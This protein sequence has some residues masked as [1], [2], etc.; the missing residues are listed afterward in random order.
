LSF[1]SSFRGQKELPAIPYRFDFF[2]MMQSVF[3]VNIVPYIF[4]SFALEVIWFEHARRRRLLGK[5]YA[6]GEPLQ[7][8][9]VPQ[10]IYIPYR[11][12]AYH[13]SET[14]GAIYKEERKSLSDFHFYLVNLLFASS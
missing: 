13:F 12:F 8:D 6:H 7:P 1:S 3:S 2:S 9:V 5:T 11:S 4:F 10:D 14:R